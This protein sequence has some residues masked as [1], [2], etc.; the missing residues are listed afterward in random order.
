MKLKTAMLAA[1]FTSAVIFTSNA[2]QAQD[3]QVVVYLQNI[4]QNLDLSISKA[5]SLCQLPDPGG[6]TCNGERSSVCQIAI[7]YLAS[8]QDLINQGVLSPSSDTYNYVDQVRSAYCP[9]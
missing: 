5:D 9:N 6:I 1:T 8:L 7:V 4:K 3:P 2:V